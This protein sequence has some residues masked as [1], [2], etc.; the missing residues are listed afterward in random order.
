M[1]THTT[2]VAPRK[3]LTEDWRPGERRD[4]LEVPDG[5]SLPNRK[6]Y[7]GKRSDGEGP[8]KTGL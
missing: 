7:G 3:G 5:T 2:R 4:V 8:G 6:G 1:Y